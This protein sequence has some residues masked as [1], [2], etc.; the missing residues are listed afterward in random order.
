MNCDTKKLYAVNVPGLDKPIYILSDPLGLYL[1][2][3]Y[4]I[5]RYTFSGSL[6]PCVTCHVSRVT[7]HVSHVTSHMS[8]V[9]FKK[10]IWTKW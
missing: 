4:E 7:C 3:L 10:K 6:P 1:I 8:R 9:T 5:V 2:I